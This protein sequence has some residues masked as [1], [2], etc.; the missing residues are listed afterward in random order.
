MSRKS[1]NFNT[2]WT[3]EADDQLRSLAASG[4]QLNI[5]AQALNRS[6]G[7]VRM[8]A[9]RLEIKIAKPRKLMACPAWLGLSQDRTSFVFL[10][11]RAAIVRRIFELSVAGL[12]GYT[13]AKQLNAQL[14]PPFGTS[15]L[16]DQS[17]IHNMLSNRATIGEYHP[18]RY[19]SA[20]D[21]PNGVRD[22]K[23]V[24][25]G[26]VVKGYYPA[27]IDEELFDKAQHARRD[28]LATGR[29]RK[30]RLITN[31]F[32]GIPT[33][34]YCGASVRFHS[35]G[36]DKSLI[37]SSVLKKQGCRRRGWSYKSFEDSFLKLVM[38][39][40]L[41]GTVAQSHREQ[42]IEL[43]ILIEEASSSAN[44][45][46]ARLTL[47]LALKAAISKLEMASGGATPISDKPSA[48]IRRDDPA[49]SFEVSFFGGSTRVC[50][51]AGEMRKI[52]D[53]A[54]N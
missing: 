37:C 14:V 8:R 10:P 16:W 28:H 7:S 21:R 9:S 36:S 1:A 42:L 31:L 3:S 47:M 15:P 2:L 39:V 41:E 46:N 4:K 40:D 53:Q 48:R 43:Q 17:T 6:I 27:V 52:R 34:A 26:K 49:R 29:G 20:Q 13:I 19:A 44:V 45:Y 38:E 51:A 32:A 24:P 54:R 25:T 11:D 30:G 33:C 23:G 18:R 12:G 22:R 50:S 5:I 35:N